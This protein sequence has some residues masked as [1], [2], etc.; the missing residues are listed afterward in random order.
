VSS[1]FAPKMRPNLATPH[2]VFSLVLAFRWHRAN[3][4]ATFHVT[5]FELG[6]PRAGIFFFEPKFGNVHCAA[7]FLPDERIGRWE[8]NIRLHMRKFVVETN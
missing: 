4:R 6:L 2:A 7:I 8:L 3:G 5:R 1:Q